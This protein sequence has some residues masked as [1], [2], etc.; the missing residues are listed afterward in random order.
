MNEFCETVQR[1]IDD[2]GIQVVFADDAIVVLD[3]PSALLSVPGRGPDKQDCLSARVQAQ[4]SDAL[5]VHRLDMAT[6]GLIVMARGAQVQRTLA[7]AF[8][9]RM[10]AKCYEA[11]VSGAVDAGTDD[12]RTIDLPIAVDW[13]NRP[14]QHVNFELGKPARTLWRVIA[15]EAG[16][17]RVELRPLTGRTHQLRVHAAAARSAG[18]LGAPILGD[19]LYGDPSSAPRLML[20]ASHL[21]FWEPFLGDWRKFS[22]DAPF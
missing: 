17:T 18:G 6:S 4:F 15:R 11:V 10:V 9:N 2:A 5:V 20:H 12:W 13:P 3:K 1:P 8:A 19:L 22:S 7:E 14:R 16:R 21:A